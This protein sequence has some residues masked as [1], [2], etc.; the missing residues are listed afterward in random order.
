[1]PRQPWICVFVCGWLSLH[2][3]RPGVTAAESVCYRAAARRGLSELF[4]VQCAALE[5]RVPDAWLP[6]LPQAR[7]KN[8]RKTSASRAG[9]SI[10]A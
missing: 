6:D 9:S 5:G 2:A 10:R 7:A 4:R 1:M 8:P 3:A